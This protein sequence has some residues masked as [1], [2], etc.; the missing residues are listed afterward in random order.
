MSL[1]MITRILRLNKF[2]A[3]WRFNPYGNVNYRKYFN[4]FWILNFN[5]K[6]EADYLIDHVLDDSLNEII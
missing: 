2:D 1:H 6:I 4:Y 3:Y 5:F